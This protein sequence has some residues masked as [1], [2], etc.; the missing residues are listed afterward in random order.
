MIDKQYGHA[1][2][3]ELAFLRALGQ[4]SERSRQF[5][6][7]H[8]LER[9]RDAAGKRADWCGMDEKAI[10]TALDKMIKAET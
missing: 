2:V 3:H 10:R 6:R 5:S 4:H 8:L 9:Y 1:T 7:R